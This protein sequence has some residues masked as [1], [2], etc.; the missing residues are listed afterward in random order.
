[1]QK[2]TEK[3]KNRKKWKKKKGKKRTQILVGGR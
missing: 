1:V 2:P 3:V